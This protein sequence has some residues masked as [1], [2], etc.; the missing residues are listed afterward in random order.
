MKIATLDEAKAHF[1][2]LFIQ[3]LTGESVIITNG[4]QTL[5]LVPY[6]KK[7]PARKG[8]QLKETL[9]LSPDFNSPFPEE[10]LKK[11]YT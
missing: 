7:L 5:Q 4:T 2:Q 11:F 3:A 8:A 6:T 1:S 9:N 10:I